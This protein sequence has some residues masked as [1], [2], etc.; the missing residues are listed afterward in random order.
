MAVHTPISSYLSV[1]AGTGL[2]AGGIT[3]M[4]GVQ[5]CCK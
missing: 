2:Q 5:T 1:G 4:G 3:A